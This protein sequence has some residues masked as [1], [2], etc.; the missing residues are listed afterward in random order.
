MKRAALLAAVLLGCSG[1]ISIGSDSWGI[2]PTSGG[3]IGVAEQGG[4]GG[5]GAAGSGA[6]LIFGGAG[7]GG[8]A[9]GDT[10]TGPEADCAV[11]LASGDS[12]VCVRYLDGRVAC[13]GDNTYGQLGEPVGT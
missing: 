12:H 9:P 3:G 13:L 1:S 8:S 5:V 10:M 7:F 11:Q 6:T 4:L 2:S